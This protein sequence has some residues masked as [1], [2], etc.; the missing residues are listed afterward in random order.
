VAAARAALIRALLEDGWKAPE[1]VHERLR[2][3][4]DVLRPRLVVAS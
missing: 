4:E 2:A 3:D 1:V